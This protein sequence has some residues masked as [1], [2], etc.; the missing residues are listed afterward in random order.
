M[1]RFCIQGYTPIWPHKLIYDK[2]YGFRCKS[3]FFFKLC[4][5][6]NSKI[7]KITIFGLKWSIFVIFEQNFLQRCIL[8]SFRE[9]LNFQEPIRMWYSWIVDFLILWLNSLLDT[10]IFKKICQEHFRMNH[11]FR[12]WRGKSK[13]HMSAKIPLT[14]V[15]T[16][17]IGIFLSCIVVRR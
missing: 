13:K 16:P 3:V 6:V 11:S 14:Y 4:Q 17:R 10:W 9:P 12:K 15:R 8:W 1:R 7:W 2:Q 5:N